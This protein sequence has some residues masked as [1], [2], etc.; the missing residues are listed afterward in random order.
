MKVYIVKHHNENSREIIKCF[1]WKERAKEWCE[2]QYEENGFL[3]DNRPN[4][5]GTVIYESKEKN[6]TTDEPVTMS[7]IWEC[8]VDNNKARGIVK[9]INACDIKV[10]DMYRC[11]FDRFSIK[12][13]EVRQINNHETAFRLD[14][15]EE[16]FI[17]NNI[18]KIEILKKKD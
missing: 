11:V 6:A 9:E 5:D 8:G 1:R 7:F 16:W 3:I 2:S 13:A 18:E 12:V 10:G 15:S 14:T 17:K 4:K